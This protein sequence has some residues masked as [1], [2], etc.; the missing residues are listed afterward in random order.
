MFFFPTLLAICKT[1]S[2]QTRNPGYTRRTLQRETGVRTNTDGTHTR[3]Q[4]Q[5]C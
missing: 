5:V 1:A 2:N 4:T 3:S